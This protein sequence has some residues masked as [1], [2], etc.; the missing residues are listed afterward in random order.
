VSVFCSVATQTPI[1]LPPYR[2]IA[3]PRGICWA[4]RLAQPRTPVQFNGESRVRCM[5][6]SDVEIARA[7]LLDRDIEN[8]Q[9]RPVTE[10]QQ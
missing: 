5:R 6:L 2:I 1:Y 3:K 4:T 8:V 10:R 9:R 7:Q